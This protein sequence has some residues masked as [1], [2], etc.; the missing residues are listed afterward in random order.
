VS[1]DGVTDTATTAGLTGAFT[2]AAGELPG[3][4]AITLGTF[5]SNNGY[6]ISFTAGS[7]LTITQA[8]LTGALS[9]GATKIYGSSDP[10]AASLGVTLTGVV[11]N[12]A[13][14]TWNGTVAIDDTATVAGVLTSL[15]RAVGENVGA[16]NYTGGTIALSGAAAGN[17]SGAAFL[18][19]ANL[20]SITPAALSVT[21]NNANRAT[22]LPNPAFSASYSG[23]QF[24]ETPAVLSGALA[25]ST[26]A[27]AGSPAGIYSITPS[28]QTS[29]NYNVTYFNGLLTVAGPPPAV[30]NGTLSSAQLAAVKQS[31][32]GNAQLSSAAAC[33]CIPKTARALAR[34]NLVAGSLRRCENLFDD[35]FTE[36]EGL[37]ECFRL[38]RNNF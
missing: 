10:A 26:A 22:G 29:A 17:Y 12:P 16:Y 20:L 1:D 3:T 8:A 30:T 31:G 34:D 19:N 14:V 13:I 11:N 7:A 21:A 4:R 2:R 36:A 5:T 35:D 18:P 25:F 27:T 6:G 23:F 28:A 38:S 32:T 33:V 24:G 37:N 9:G 15:T